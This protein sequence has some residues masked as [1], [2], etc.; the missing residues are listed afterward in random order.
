MHESTT[1]MGTI[2]W[3]AIL[4]VGFILALAGVAQ[5]GSPTAACDDLDPA[6]C[7]LPFPNDLFTAADASTDSGRRVAFASLP[8]NAAGQPLDATEWNR[9]D[10]FSP[11]TPVLTF[12]PELDLPRSWGTEN[13][14]TSLPGIGPNEPGYFDHRD[15]IAAPGRYQDPDGSER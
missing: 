5:A 11:G 3:T 4:A 1:K 2:S 10:G 15:H 7:L 12:V 8:S 6:H 13:E 14:P 9:N